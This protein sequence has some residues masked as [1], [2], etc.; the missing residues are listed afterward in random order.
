MFSKIVTMKIEEI[1]QED[2]G[3]TLEFKENIKAEDKIISTLIA[4][5]N[6]SGGRMIV[7]VQDVTR[8]IIGVEDPH[9]VAEAMANKIHDMIE[10][11]I[12]PNV[13][14][15]PYRNTHLISVE[16]YPSSVR[17]HYIRS[18]GKEKSTYVRIGST[19]RQA[20]SSL[21]KVIE[22]STFTKTFDEELCYETNCE[23]IDFTVASQLFR[24]YR[25]L[26]QGDLVSLGILVKNGR[27]L[28]PTI[29]GV[30]LFGKNR[31]KFF[32]DAWIQVGA[33]EGFEKTKILDTKKITAYFPEAIEEALNFVKRNLRIG[34]KIDG[35]QHQEIWE[36][37]KV[38]LRE[39]I[40]NAVV[41]TDYSLGGTIRVAV[42]EDRVEVEN[43]ALLPWGLTFEDLKAGVSKLRNP[44]IARIFNELGLIEQW[45]SGIQR[46]INACIKAG[47]ESPHFEEIGPRIRVT[48]Y[49]KIVGQAVTND[50][51]Q[52]IFSLLTFC[53]PLS[54]HQITNCITLSRRSVINRLS[55]LVEKGQIIELAQN[56]NDPKKKYS[57]KGVTEKMKKMNIIKDM[58]WYDDIGHRRQLLVRFELGKNCLDL[59]FSQ[60]IVDDYFLDGGGSILKEKAKVAVKN[61]ISYDPIFSEILLNVLMD[62]KVQEAFKRKEIAKYKVYPSDFRERDYR[63]ELG[64]LIRT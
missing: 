47:L 23:D 39:A 2:E 22:R 34:L 57:L 51:D 32:P 13:E 10:P 61:V 35:I 58:I 6:T 59:V 45:G 31:L 21:L 16:V 17:P 18:K 25:K 63:R 29:A 54:T 26:Q 56:P 5:A 28:L 9:K 33:F 8:H 14:V 7:G 60:N 44:I 12:L 48:F 38:A 41:H 40:I 64:E 1:L 43:S 42:F 55:A 30:L 27:E 49:K 11:R 24:P 20:D 4:F 36:I 46:M 50:F 19:T 52:Y 37:P 62:E 15:I 3:T 53:G